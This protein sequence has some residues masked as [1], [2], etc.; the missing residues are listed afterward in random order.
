MGRLTTNSFADW[1]LYDVQLD[2]ADRWQA[3]IAWCSLAALVAMVLLFVVGR[4][5]AGHLSFLRT[6]PRPTSPAPSPHFPKTRVTTAIA[7]LLLLIFSKYFYLAS[8]SSY[9]TF[10]LIQRFGVSVEAA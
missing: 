6:N 1:A 10:Y 7:I 8:L 9:Y 2:G 4:W 3:S 5:Y